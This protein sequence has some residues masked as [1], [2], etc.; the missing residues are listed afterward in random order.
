ML[1][2]DTTDCDD[3]WNPPPTGKLAGGIR[4]LECERQGERYSFVLHK[5]VKAYSVDSIG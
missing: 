5:C 4:P 1:Q 2:V 3:C